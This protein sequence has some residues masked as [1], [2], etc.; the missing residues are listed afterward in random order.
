MS[1]SHEVCKTLQSL[2]YRSGQ[3]VRLYGEE[4]QITSDPFLDGEHIAVQAIN[5][6]KTSIQKVVRI[7]ITIVHIAHQ[8]NAA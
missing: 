4:L 5:I 3:K 6:G 1:R 2:G 7:P 8:R